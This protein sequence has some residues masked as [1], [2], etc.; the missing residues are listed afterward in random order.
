M[1]RLEQ[2]DYNSW[3]ALPMADNLLLAVDNM[4]QVRQAALADSEMDDQQALKL[5]HQMQG[6]KAVRTFLAALIESSR[7]GEHE[8]N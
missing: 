5:V 3:L 1:L 4:V 8:G 6:A 2:D 7:S